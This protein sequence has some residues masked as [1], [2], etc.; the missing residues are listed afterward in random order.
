MTISMDFVYD[1]CRDIGGY[2]WKSPSH[3]NF[4]ANSE[5]T[6]IVHDFIDH[7][8]YEDYDT[9]EG[10]L[11]AFGVIAYS[12]LQFGTVGITEKSMAA[13]IAGFLIGYW[14]APDNCGIED[15]TG[16]NNLLDSEGEQLLVRV[17]RLTLK[18]LLDDLQHM[19]WDEPPSLAELVKTRRYVQNW[20]RYGWNFA[21][22]RF[23]TISAPRLAE[24]F[25]ELV[26]QVL[27]AKRGIDESDVGSTLTLSID[28][29]TVEA[30]VTVQRAS[31]LYDEE[32]EGELAEEDYNVR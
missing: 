21:L 30:S 15:V 1:Y 6:G 11:M 25:E 19:G 24:L 12:R 23:P 20:L 14:T 29:D 28:P 4:N 10:E 5:A 22:R 13:E 16:F 26:K 2:G 31:E 3:P 32:E 27:D 8:E 9:V 7:G 18:S 17:T